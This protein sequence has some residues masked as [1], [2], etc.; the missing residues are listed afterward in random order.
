MRRNILELIPS[1]LFWDTRWRGESSK[2]GKR[3]VLARALRELRDHPYT[4]EPS[5][6]QE[7]NL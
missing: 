1:L 5:G 7:D 2:Y 4:G 6:D 3:N